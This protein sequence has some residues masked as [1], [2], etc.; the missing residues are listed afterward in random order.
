MNKKKLI[1]GNWKMNGSLAANSA[2]LQALVAGLKEV[3]CDVALAVPAVY[4]A[5][6]QTL[7]QGSD[8]AL[9]A[10]DVSQHE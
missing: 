6:V 7:V 4:L 9:A 5:Q 1:A 3:R 2:L 10:Q 8:V